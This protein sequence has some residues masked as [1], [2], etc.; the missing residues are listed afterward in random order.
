MNL[1][2][3]LITYIILSCA[4][5]YLM[6]CIPTAYL[7]AKRNGLDIFAI[8]TKSAGTA[9]VYR[10][11]SRSQ[12]LLV[13]VIDVTKG[14]LSLALPLILALPEFT[15]FLAAFFSVAGHWNSVFTGFK[16]GDS[17][18]SMLGIILVLIPG[19][20]VLAI[21]I[22]CLFVFICKRY[23]YRSSIGLLICCGILLT[24]AF[25][26]EENMF[27]AFGL[28]LLCNIVIAHNIYKGMKLNSVLPVSKTLDL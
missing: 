8:G 21:L 22:G 20:S 7:I 19:V 2:T 25:F 6:G 27:I 5:A 4:T 1:T 15:L 14:A 24:L 10:N 11:I 9:N 3:Q 18:A 16:G 17:M 26:S 12:G 28:F 13:F 23:K